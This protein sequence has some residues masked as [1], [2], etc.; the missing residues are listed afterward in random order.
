M[1]AIAPDDRLLPPSLLGNFVFV[2]VSDAP[3]FVSSVDVPSLPVWLV[4]DVCVPVGVVVGLVRV[5]VVVLVGVD[6]NDVRVTTDVIVTSS[7][8]EGGAVGWLVAEVGVVGVVGV[9]DVGVVGVVDVGVVCV[10][11]VGGGSLVG[12]V[13]VGVVWVVGVVDVAAPVLEGST[14]EEDELWDRTTAG[15]K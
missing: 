7:V 4:S 12:V 11:D 5:V 15:D 8:S 3:G 1:P 13:D 2:S 6:E 9:V 10:V 14:P